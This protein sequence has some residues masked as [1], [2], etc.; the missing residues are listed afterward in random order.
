MKIESIMLAIA[1]VSAA[2]AVI[3]SKVEPSTLNNIAREV[4][5]KAPMVIMRQ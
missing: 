2:V 1:L 4:A 5:H 3:V